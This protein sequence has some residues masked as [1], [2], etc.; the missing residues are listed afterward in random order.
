MVSK[1]DLES[2]SEHACGS[3]FVE[4]IAIVDPFLL[5]DALIF[6][7]AFIIL[8]QAIVLVE[9]LISRFCRAMLFEGEES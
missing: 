1:V 2:R 5:I 4:S 3:H 6:V 9:A 8:V 7:V